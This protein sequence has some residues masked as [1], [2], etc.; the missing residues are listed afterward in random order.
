MTEYERVNP[1]TQ[2]EA[3]KEWFIEI[4]KL[5]ETH[6]LKD[7]DGNLINTNQQQQNIMQQNLASLFQ[8]IP[9]Q[10]RLNNL[11]NYAQNNPTSLQMQGMGL[12]MN[13]ANNYF[14]QPPGQIFGQNM[15]NQPVLINPFMANQ[16]TNPFRNN[17]QQMMTMNRLMSL[18]QPSQQVKSEKAK[19][20]VAFHIPNS[21][22]NA[23]PHF[24]S[25]FPQ[26]KPMNLAQEMFN[27]MQQSQ[28]NQM[29]QAP[30]NYPMGQPQTDAPFIV[31]ADP[32]FGFNPQLGQINRQQSPIRQQSFNH[33]Q[34]MSGDIEQPNLDGQDIDLEVEIPDQ[35][36]RDGGFAVQA[37]PQFGF[38]QQ[39]AQVDMH[40]FPNGR[41]G[42]NR[43]ITKSDDRGQPDQFMGEGDDISS[44]NLD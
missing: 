5:P 18:A 16:Q 21:N 39:R 40:H 31:E 38:N 32:Q 25:H 17:F 41:A 20:E 12:N 22:P 9:N 28:M 11:A 24:A 2:A 33:P 3:M 42:L 27:P 26:Q 15:P 29:N 13:F 34:T 8:H 36:R 37:N 10:T 35:R 43:S 1:I 19:P 4:S 30:R 7:A 44:N 6:A 23:A 14:P